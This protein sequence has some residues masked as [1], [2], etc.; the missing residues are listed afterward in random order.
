MSLTIQTVPTVVELPKAQSRIGVDPVDWPQHTLDHIFAYGL[1]Q[2]LNDAM[3]SAKSADEAYGMAQKRLDN[4][5]A[6]TLR[7]APN[8]TGDPV[9]RR[10]KEL[11]EA[12]IRVNAAFTAWL[13]K[14]G[15]KPSS[16]EAK[17]KLAALVADAVAKPGNKFVEQAK[18]DVAK[19][20]ELV[21][22]DLDL[23]DLDGIESDETE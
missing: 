7:A 16:K 10:A 2:I 17:A 13:G 22:D 21:V 11:A 6:G 1:R 9:A 4:L 3:A 8:R 12:A 5:I 14:N 20:K 18:I 19:A 23:G 15:L